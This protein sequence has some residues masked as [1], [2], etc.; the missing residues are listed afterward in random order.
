MNLHQIL[1]TDYRIKKPDM[2][3]AF[4]DYFLLTISSLVLSGLYFQ[5]KEP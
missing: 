4:K 1:K 5:Q 3:Y 2:F